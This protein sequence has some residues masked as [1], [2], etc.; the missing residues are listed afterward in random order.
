MDLISVI[1]NRSADSEK[2]AQS[3]WRTRMMEGTFNAGMICVY[4]NEIV[5]CA[6]FHVLV[7]FMLEELEGV[8]HMYVAYQVGVQ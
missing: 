1:V 4:S 8:Q 7:S 6:C 2:C 3:I 5:N